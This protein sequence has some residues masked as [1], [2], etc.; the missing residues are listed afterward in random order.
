MPRGTTLLETLVALTVIGILGGGALW[1]FARFN[2]R[3]RVDVEAGRILAAY[4]RAQVHAT[5]LG[6][7]TDLLVTQDSLV[8][9][10]IGLT[11]TTLVWRA[12]GPTQSGVSLAPALHVS[13][14]APSGAGRGPSN[15]THVLTRGGAQRRVVV[16]RVGRVRVQ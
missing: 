5:A 9:R 15:A 14:Y 4:R 7:P 1:S 10:A 16:S 3:L 12:V 11:D 13:G 8:I 6:L 2:D